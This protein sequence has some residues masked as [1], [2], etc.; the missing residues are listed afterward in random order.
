[1]EI[2][3]SVNREVSDPAVEEFQRNEGRLPTRRDQTA[4]AAVV[5]VCD[6][7]FEGVSVSEWPR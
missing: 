7:F 1:V 6:P 4:P 2:G 3:E 5:L